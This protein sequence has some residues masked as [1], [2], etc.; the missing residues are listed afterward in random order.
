MDPNYLK[1][2]KIPLK[3]LS[4]FKAME[5]EDHKV[6][7]HSVC[8]NPFSPKEIL[9][10][11]GI[12]EHDDENNYHVVCDICNKSF[13]D[14]VGLV[15]HKKNV[16]DSTKYECD[17]CGKKLATNSNLMS[18]KK[19]HADSPIT[20]ISHLGSVPTVCFIKA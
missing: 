14:K 18:H 7:E 11:D 16:H 13:Q 3:T 2:I 12:Y 15:R 20:P 5:T 17:I 1:V 9:Q 4:A 6:F 8:K 19:I 10:S